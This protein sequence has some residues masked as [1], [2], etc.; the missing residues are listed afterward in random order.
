M[1]GMAVEEP[2][3]EKHVDDDELSAIG[4]LGG[5]RDD[6]DAAG[7]SDGGNHSSFMMVPRSLAN[8]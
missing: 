8:Q 3:P 2:A 1:S 7:E 5:S 6:D 4:C